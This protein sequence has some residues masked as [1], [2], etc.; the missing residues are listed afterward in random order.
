[1]NASQ[2]FGAIKIFLKISWKIWSDFLPKNCTCA[3]EKFSVKCQGTQRVFWKTTCELQVKKPRWKSFFANWF[4]II[5]YN[6]KSSS[7]P[8]FCDLPGVSLTVSLL[9]LQFTLVQKEDLLANQIQRGHS[10]LSQRVLSHLISHFVDSWDILPLISPV[11]YPAVQRLGKPCQ[12]H[13]PFSHYWWQKREDNKFLTSHD[14]PNM[15]CSFMASGL[16]TCVS[17]CQKHVFFS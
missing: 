5:V 4:R 1:M 13:N 9:L 16:S 14:F 6:P 15:P 12:F 17:L 10:Q 11:A 3:Q 8:G 7:P 2:I